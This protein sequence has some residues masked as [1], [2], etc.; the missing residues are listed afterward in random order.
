MKDTVEESLYKLNK[1]RDSGSF[2]S[3]NKKGQD[4]PVLTLKDVESLF[5]VAP[6][7]AAEQKKEESTSNLMHLPPAVAAG[8][9]AERRLTEQTM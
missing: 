9:A 1:S 7:T 2:I 3:G 5:K 6:S 4:Q 8:I